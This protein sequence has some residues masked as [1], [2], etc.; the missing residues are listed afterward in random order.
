MILTKL[1]MAG[2]DAADAYN[3]LRKIYDARNLKIGQ[4]FVL[5]G[6]F[7]TQTHELETLDTL[8]IEPERGTRYTLRTN[9]YDKFE[10]KVEQEKT[11]ECKNNRTKS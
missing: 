11:N 6:T 7:N 10:T 9:E 8:I 1:G 5:I 3:T 2:K 4:Y